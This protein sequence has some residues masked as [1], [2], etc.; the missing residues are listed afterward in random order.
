ML[1][2]CTLQGFYGILSY[3]HKTFQLL[4]TFPLSSPV[5][6]LS[7][8]PPL[9]LPTPNGFWSS[10]MCRDFR[11]GWIWTLGLG[12]II[13]KPAPCACPGLGRRKEL[14]IYHFPDLWFLRAVLCFIEAEIILFECLVTSVPKTRDLS[15]PCALEEEQRL[16]LSPGS[17]EDLPWP[18]RVWGFRSFGG[19]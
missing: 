12:R 14:H 13:R 3:S 15:L 9:L 19:K 11:D 18:G 8:F 17:E 10:L 1:A 7:C 5:S 4:C 2:L 16:G 6:H